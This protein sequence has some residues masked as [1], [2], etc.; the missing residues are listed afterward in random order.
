M[1][2]K[3]EG[4]FSLDYFMES[5]KSGGIEKYSEISSKASYFDNKNLNFQSPYSISVLG[6]KI[7]HFYFCFFFL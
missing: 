3:N 2:N 5:M 6:L 1:K 4:G 7:L